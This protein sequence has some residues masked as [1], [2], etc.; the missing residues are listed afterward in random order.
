MSMKLSKRLEAVLSLVTPGSLLLDIGCDHG[1]VPIA[2]LR[3]GIVKRALASDVRPGPLAAA[4][5]HVKA[6]GLK[7]SVMLTCCDG[8][9]ENFPTLLSL[10]EDDRVSCVIAGMGGMLEA[11]I[12]RK[13]QKLLDRIDEFVLS[14]QSDL[15][16]FR[17][18]LC[19]L[20]LVIDRELM[21]EEDG[22]FYTIIHAR[23]YKRWGRAEQD[24]L[25]RDSLDRDGLKRDDLERDEL[26]PARLDQTEPG[27]EHLVLSPIELEFGPYL[28]RT[29]N[30]VLKTYLLKRQRDLFKIRDNLARHGSEEARSRLTEIEDQIRMVETALDRYGKKSEP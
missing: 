21:V 27:R 24:C 12:L 2:L 26:D 5:G 9:P 30:P 14:P 28:L 19:E 7:D 8:I 1:Y 16:K 13:R 17:Q 23:P 3:R 18:T 15:S 10:K 29:G 11:D 4:A 25:D 6:A 22:K 20:D